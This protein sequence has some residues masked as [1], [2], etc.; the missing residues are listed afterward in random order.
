MTY[1]AKK[2]LVEELFEDF[3]SEAD[4]SF[5]DWVYDQMFGLDEG[6]IPTDELI[7]G[8]GEKQIDVIRVDDDTENRR[9][10][11][12]VLQTKK[13]GGFAANTVILISNGIST[14]FE[15]KKSEVQKL[16]NTTLVGKIVEIRDI[17]KRYGYSAVELHVRY[18]TLGNTHD[19][20]QESKEAKQTLIDKW[21]GLGF[22]SLSFEFLGASELYDIWW[23]KNTADRNIDQD[24]NIIYD[25]NKASIIEFA[26]DH[27]KAVVCTVSG[28]EVARLA[29]LE[30]KDAIFDMNLRGH[31]GITGRVNS[32]IYQASQKEAEAKTFWFKNNGITMVCSHLDVV[33][34]P[35]EPAVKVRNV[36]IVNGCQTSVTLRESAK[37]GV[38]HE[39]VRVLAKIYEIES[40]DLISKIV[41]ATNN[42]NA[43]ISRDLFAND[44][45][46]SLIQQAI[47]AKLG[48]FYE[49]KRGEARSKG[50][51]RAE[52]IDSE[53]AGQAYLAIKKK[54][55]TISRAQ[56]YRIYEN[57]LYSDIF[58]KSDPL[59]LALCYFIYE[60]S[61]KKGQKRAK[62][63]NKGEN[64]H[65]L[66]TYGVFHLARA[67]AFFIF[68]DE[69]LPKNEAK[70]KSV[71]SSL[72]AGDASFDSPF[73]QAVKLC[74]SALRKAK[75]PSANNYFKSQ[76]AQQQITDAIAKV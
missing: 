47:A 37:E 4:G 17:L 50:R 18:A 64:V 41:L 40:S 73:N 45:G 52:T 54:L 20:G 7:E 29:S 58:Q 60:Y 6:E 8:T 48:F 28:A 67:F 55:P 26:V 32:S 63:L 1:V 14:I 69:E 16:T 70:I 27:Y 57:E 46:Q 61:K 11:I 22:S 44:E 31:L 30:P 65:S 39:A 51:H 62:Q 43:I 66:L 42:Q 13:T 68:S 23:R 53:K 24:I 25:V 5:L 35:D 9:A 71:I 75:V 3:H 56:K 19:I 15:K 36:Q 34:D 59:Q 33:K 10:I 72:R 49:R 38:L 76:I 21:S 74:S 2:T 12:Q